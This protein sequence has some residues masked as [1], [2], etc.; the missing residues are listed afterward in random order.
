M[1]R[2]EIINELPLPCDAVASLE[3]VSKEENEST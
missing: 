2:A 3:V 1:D